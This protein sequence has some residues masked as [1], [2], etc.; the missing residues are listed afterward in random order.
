MRYSR[1]CGVY[2]DSANGNNG[3]DDDA[4][5]EY[6]QDTFTKHYEGNRQPIGLYT[7]PIHVSVGP[8]RQ[9]LGKS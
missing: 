7:H 3:V 9:H 5:L 6:M 1:E 2:R 8:N 4:T